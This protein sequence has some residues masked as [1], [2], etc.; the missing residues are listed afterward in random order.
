MWVD[1][2]NKNVM[3]IQFMVVVVEVASGA[4]VIVAATAVETLSDVDNR[5]VFFPLARAVAAS[6]TVHLATLARAFVQ[7]L[8]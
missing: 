6:D 4:F 2:R 3:L 1:Q 5:F 7:R 8:V